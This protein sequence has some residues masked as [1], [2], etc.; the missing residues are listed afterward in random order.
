M[1][2]VSIAMVGLLTLLFIM[3]TIVNSASFD[4]LE[5]DESLERVGILESALQNEVHAIYASTKDYATWGDTYSFMID[6]NQTYV[7]VNLIPETFRNLEMSFIILVNTSGEIAFGKEY[8]RTT[9]ALDP[10]PPGIIAH[11][12]LDGMIVSNCIAGNETTGLIMVDGRPVLFA[13]R[14]ILTSE[15]LGP[16]EG[17]LLMGRTMDDVL[18]NRLENST[19]LPMWLLELNDPSLIAEVGDAA[20]NELVNDQRTIHALSESTMGGYTLAKDIYGD[21]GV[22]IKVTIERSI[23]AQGIASLQSLA[24]LLTIASLAFGIVTFLLLERTVVSRLSNLRQE[25][26]R[27]DPNSASELKVSSQGE[28]EIGGLADSINEMLA[29]IETD[30]KKLIE[31]EKRYRLLVDSAVEAIVVAQD[32]MLRLVNPTAVAWIGFS[33]EELLSRPFASFIHPDDRTMMVEN[34]QRRLRGEDVPNRYIFRLLAKD[35]N[36]RWAEISAVAI[37]WE[38]RPATLNFLTDITERKKVEDALRESE[39]RYRSLFDSTLEG[40]AVHEILCDANGIP[41]DYR[42]LDVNPMFEKM[43][44]LGREKMI[45]RTVHE[46]L[47]KIESSWIE[48][49]GRVALTGKPEFFTQYT[50]S[51]GKTFEVSVY[52]NAPRQFT[53]SFNDVTERKRAEEALQENEAKIRTYFDSSP[54][55]I[56]IVDATGNYQDVN[57]T[58]CSMLGYSRKEILSL[59]LLSLLEKSAFQ[60]GQEGFQRLKEKGELAVETV[61]VRKDGIDLPTFMNAVELPGQRYM[62]FCTDITERKRAEAA[63]RLANLKLGILNNITRHDINNQMMVI[64]GFIELC[65]MRDKDPDFAKYLDKMSNAASNVLG[66]IAF[67]KDYQELGIHAPAWASVSRRI[68]D[69]FNSL[70]PPGVVLENKVDGV[71]ILT[72][73]MA[74]KVQYNLIDN[75]IRHGRHVTHI[76]MSTEQVGDAMLVVY[77]DNGVGISDDDRGRL[78][79]KGFGKNTGYGLFII[80]EILAIT[81]ITIVERGQAGKGVRFEMLV[82]PGAWR[83]NPPR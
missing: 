3:S 56:F 70:H 43:V 15:V 71:E 60:A 49:Y 73:P 52:R 44:G 77:E 8:N 27:L 57:A 32:G 75:S 45:G 67:T 20:W 40:I 25:V 26:S 80:R 37:D 30:K 66:Q 14:P 36:F 5:K 50:E 10:L 55:G 82:P 74:E 39:V 12:S 38:G 59:N 69:A 41:I 64:N 81:G 22:V 63:L 76:R 29:T 23:H 61:L 78:F 31:S 21:P 65:K 2:L 7:D 68:T 16:S 34:L 28:D 1:V 35:E 51:M 54:E 46:V 72:D 19:G 9:Q 47:P 33:E 17:A 83:I 4:K 48:R 24:I 18:L 42:F 79:E 53:T 11:L 6:Q 58:G 62:A 13:A